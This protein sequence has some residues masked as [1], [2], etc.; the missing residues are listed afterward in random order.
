[1]K[2]LAP[3]L[4]VIIMLTLTACQTAE[5]PAAPESY[6]QNS[7]QTM[8]PETC[9]SFFDGCNN[10]RREAGSDIA[11]CTRKFCPEYEKPRCLDGETAD[12]ATGQ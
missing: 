11:A 4:V 12:E 1:M 2:R 8:I 7:W 9:L 6:D 10:C 3:L 5:E